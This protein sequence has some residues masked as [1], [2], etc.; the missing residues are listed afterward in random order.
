MIRPLAI[1]VSLT[2]GCSLG[3]AVEL[4]PCFTP[5]DDCTSFIVQEIDI[6]TSELL[7]QGYYFT[8]MP[9]LQVI[10]MLTNVVSSSK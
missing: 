10:G 7:V 4:K 5:A 3:H 2:L 8:S 9:I 1:F 6:A